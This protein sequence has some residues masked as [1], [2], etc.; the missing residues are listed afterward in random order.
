MTN[1]LIV[2]I[3]G[4]IGSGKTTLSQLLRKFGYPVYDTDNEAR[5]LQNEHEVLVSQIKQ[6]LGD[7][8]YDSEGNLNRKAVAEQVFADPEQ[9]Q[10]LSALVHPVVR[11]DFN[12]WL[13]EQ[14]SPV[15]F[16]ESAVLLEGGFHLQTNK[17]IVIT[18]APEIRIQRVMQRD[19]I[20][21]DQV[22]AR[23]RNQMPEEEKMAKADVVIHSDNGIREEDIKKVVS[24]LLTNHFH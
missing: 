16:I 17:L 11:N 21:R 10:K 22:L 5:R 23:M 4:G 8:V 9:L 7:D 20:S 19:G 15:V 18:A 3:T 24:D 2:G 14:H 13:A 6:L 1:R 12:N